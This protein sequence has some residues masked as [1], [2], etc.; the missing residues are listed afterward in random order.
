MWCRE[1]ASDISSKFALVC[2]LSM[3]DQIQSVQIWPFSIGSAIQNKMHFKLPFYITAAPTPK[4]FIDNFKCISEMMNACLRIYNIIIIHIKL[5]IFN[6]WLIWRYYVYVT[7]ILEFSQF[8]IYTHTYLL[9]KYY[10]LI[11]DLILEFNWNSII[12]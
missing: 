4:I 8:Y 3:E 2:L 1:Y 6:F 12:Y 11:L 5:K 9:D 10:L 7:P